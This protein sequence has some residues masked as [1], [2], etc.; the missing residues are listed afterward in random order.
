MVTVTLDTQLK[1]L[2]G[3]VTIPNVSVMPVLDSG[4]RLA[5]GCIGWSRLRGFLPLTDPAVVGVNRR[6]RARPFPIQREPVQREPVQREPS[7]ARAQ[8][9]ASPVQREPS[10]ARAQS[11]ASPV[12]REPVQREP[13]PARA[14]SSAR[15]SSEASRGMYEDDT[16]GARGRRGC[17]L[18]ASALSSCSRVSYLKGGGP[19]GLTR[20]IHVWLSPAAVSHLDFCGWT[21]SLA[22][23]DK[24]LPY[25]S[26]FWTEMTT[27]AR[28]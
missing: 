1:E 4:G 11:S 27:T 14:Q 21:S 10:P 5:C 15:R 28:L 25:A 17:P 7:P 23:F 9:S 3:L 12:Q 19:W 8:S 18:F 22:P 20:Q 26:V 2:A 13:S 6:R 24:L 16:P